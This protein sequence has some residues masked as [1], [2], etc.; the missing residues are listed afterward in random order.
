MANP[1]RRRWAGPT[2]PSAAFLYGVG[3]RRGDTAWMDGTDGWMDGWMHGW[4]GCTLQWSNCT[5]PGEQGRVRPDFAVL[6]AHGTIACDAGRAAD[7][8]PPPNTQMSH[9]PV[10]YN[11]WST[12]WTK[13]LVTKQPQMGRKF[14]TEKQN[15]PPCHLSGAREQMEMLR[16][17]RCPHQCLGKF[18]CWVR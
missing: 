3:A 10:M 11:C 16:W 14:A 9:V 2:S 1:R 8:P 6:W 5:A 12:W 15:H 7:T 13:R 4:H 17:D 18:S